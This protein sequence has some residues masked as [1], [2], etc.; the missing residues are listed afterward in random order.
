VN[1]DKRPSEKQKPK[2]FIVGTRLHTQDIR[3]IH[4]AFITC[5]LR[6]S[7]IKSN[8]PIYKYHIFILVKPIVGLV[9]YFI[10][11]E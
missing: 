7:E 3:D 4:L 2:K 11:L 1:K 10:S 6:Q 8:E 5:L 9:D